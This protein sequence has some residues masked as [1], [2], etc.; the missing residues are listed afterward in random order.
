MRVCPTDPTV[1]EDTQRGP[2]G[3]PGRGNPHT[4]RNGLATVVALYAAFSPNRADFPQIFAIMC[5]C[6]VPLRQLG[7]RQ[8]RLNCSPL[9]S[10]PLPDDPDVISPAFLHGME[11]CH[12]RPLP[13]ACKQN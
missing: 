2:Y 13:L 4:Q 5:E 9:L 12:L 10:D 7:F 3:G 6:A 11:P 8:P 1:A